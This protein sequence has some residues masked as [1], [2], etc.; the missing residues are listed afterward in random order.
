ML[1]KRSK[2]TEKEVNIRPS[3]E[4]VSYK[5]KPIFSLLREVKKYKFAVGSAPGALL[6]EVVNRIDRSLR[7]IALD[8]IGGE[9]AIIAAMGKLGQKICL[10]VALPEVPVEGCA[11]VDIRDS[12]VDYDIHNAFVNRCAER[13]EEGAKLQNQIHELLKQKKVD[14]FGVPGVLNLSDD[15]CLHIAMT[16]VEGPKILVHL[17]DKNDVRYNMQKYLQLC[18]CVEMLHQYGIIHRDIKSSNIMIA[19]SPMDSGIEAIYIIDWTL[20]KQIGRDL[21]VQGEGLGT[22]PYASPK[23]LFLRQAKNATYVDDL[24]SLALCLWEFFHQQIL[25]RSLSANDYA[26]PDK[27]QAYL[28]K[29]SL[30]LPPVLRPGFEWATH[31]DERQRLQS[32]TEWKNIIAGTIDKIAPRDEYAKPEE[33]FGEALSAKSQK[34][35]KEEEIKLPCEGCKHIEYCKNICAL[36]LQALQALIAEEYL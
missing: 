34:Q 6:N 16:W 3:G 22:F 18:E 36:K 15:P 32:V 17:R 9:G 7:F 25:P 1:F 13:F 20:A 30:S 27:V 28:K 35:E 21:T 12:F 8:A 26:D 24:F 33:L 5:D 11:V 10:K 4:I 23:Q 14:F 2:K 29:L 31:I 19:A